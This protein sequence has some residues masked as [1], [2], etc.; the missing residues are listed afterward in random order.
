MSDQIA[1]VRQENCKKPRGVPC[2]RRPAFQNLTGFKGIYANP[3]SSSSAECLLQLVCNGGQSR[4]RILPGAVCRAP[5][6]ESRLWSLDSYGLHG[7]LP[8][9]ARCRIGKFCCPICFKG[10]RHT[11]P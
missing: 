10:L 11:K 1:L 5:A 3:P 6:R 4:R 7:S 8:P 9:S 2:V